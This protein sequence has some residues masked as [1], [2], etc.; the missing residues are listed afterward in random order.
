MPYSQP[1]ASTGQEPPPARESRAKGANGPQKEQHA[2]GT[3]HWNCGQCSRRGAR[4]HNDDR[5]VVITNF[6]ELIEQMKAQDMCGGIDEVGNLESGEVDVNKYGE[7]LRAGRL[8]RNSSCADV[9]HSFYAIYDGHGGC[10]AAQYLTNCLH[11][12]IA[13]CGNMYPSTRYV[14]CCVDYCM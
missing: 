6:E 5:L 1:Q 13:R 11:F 4:E 7:V 10:Q 2:L 8:L 12:M 14:V 3:L 9:C